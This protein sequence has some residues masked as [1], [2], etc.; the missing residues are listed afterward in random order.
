MTNSANTPPLKGIEPQTQENIIA[1]HSRRYWRLNTLMALRQ[2]RQSDWEAQTPEHLAAI[3]ADNAELAL[4]EAREQAVKARY[5][6]ILAQQRQPNLQAP[7]DIPMLSPAAKQGIT[8]ELPLSVSTRYLRIK[9]IYY[10]QDKTVAFEDRGTVLKID[11]EN[12]EVIRDA[13]LIAETRGWQR[14]SVSGSQPFKCQVWREA[15]LKGMTVTGYTPTPVEVAELKQTQTSSAMQKPMANESASKT[16]T[17]FEK[18]QPTELLRG[19]LV[20]HGA[21]HYQHDPKQPRSYFVQL[22]VAGTEV[23]RWGIDFQR[24]FKESRSKP[25]LGDTVILRNE[26][27][28]PLELTT[29][30]G[31]DNGNS[32]NQAK[33]SVRKNT[34]RVEKA[35]YHDTLQEQA[36]A[37]RVGQDIGHKVLEQ[38]PQL[39]AALTVAKLGE[40]IAQQAKESGALRSQDE[41]DTLVALIREGLAAALKNGKHI[42]TPELREQGKPSAIDASYQKPPEIVKEPPQ[43]DWAITR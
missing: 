25:Q 15:S 43:Q 30:T 20:A 5:D 14:L 2:T 35:D 4:L 3:K 42:K 36:E 27:R 19:I 16:K 37:L 41:V 13:V 1:L 34:W 10:F 17:P 11:T 6:R 31:A 28:Q 40:K 7:A 22:A 23:T 29:R 33:K 9:N 32:V 21:D 12:R 38:M 24:A 8:R 39:A 26:G 18:N